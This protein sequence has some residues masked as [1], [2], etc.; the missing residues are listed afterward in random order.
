MADRNVNQIVVQLIDKLTGPA[1]NVERSMKGIQQAAKSG[2]LDLVGF[3]RALFATTAFVG[4]VQRAFTGMFRSIETGAELGRLTDQFERAIGPRGRFFATIEQFTDTAIDRVEALRAGVELANLGISTN[5]TQIASLLSKAATAAKRSGFDAATGIKE[6]TAFLKDGSTA[7]LENIGLINRANMSYMVQQRI[8]E[9]SGGAMGGVIALQ[10]RYTL[11]QYLLDQRT[12]GLIRGHRDLV[13]VVQTAKNAFITLSYEIGM[14]L[15][16]ALT[17]VIDKISSAVNKFSQFLDHLRKNHRGMLELAKS[18]IIATATLTA[19]LATVVV[20]RN[21]V[22]GIVSL[23]FGLKGFFTIFL[24]LALADKLINLTNLLANLSKF[25]QDVTHQLI[26]WLSPISRVIAGIGKIVG[27]FY[28]WVTG[29]KLFKDSGNAVYEMVV[30]ITAATIALVGAFKA[31]AIIKTAL[32]FGSLVRQFIILN[33]AM[34]AA[35][36]TST[37]LAL[38]AGLGMAAP[39]AGAIK[40]GALALGS[41]AGMA[42]ASA[43]GKSHSMWAEVVA[44]IVGSVAGRALGVWAGRAIGGA[45]GTLVAP[46]VGSVAGGVA[47]GLIVDKLIGAFTKNTDRTIDAIDGVTNELSDEQTDNALPTMPDTQLELIGRIADMMGGIRG[48]QQSVFSEAFRAAVLPMSEGGKDVT[49]QEYVKL[50]KI[51]NGFLK[52]IRDSKANAYS[53][54]RKDRSLDF[55][56]GGFR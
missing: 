31:L 41:T 52:D 7:H 32:T 15:G 24:S 23:G 39:G 28:E 13:D 25:I 11:G 6:Y 30:K 38:A 51:A 20:F 2:Q 17:P 44:P 16:T 1:R 54:P 46:G 55:V 35:R 3:N 36:G 47:G 29:A 14:F 34:A 18:F 4:T 45:L 56:S 53:G 27:V 22:A 8:L 12:S 49:A 5:A 21:V 48:E 37:G 50:Q 43:S 42:A 9:A 33:A 40:Y 26:E 10:A 19:F